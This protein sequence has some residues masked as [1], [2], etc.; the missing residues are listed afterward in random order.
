MLLTWN[1]TKQ[2]NIAQN[3]VHIKFHETVLHQYHL[4]KFWFVLLQ[5]ESNMQDRMSRTIREQY[6]Y[7]IQ[8]NEDNLRLTEAWDKAQSSV[9]ILEDEISISLFLSSKFLLSI[10]AVI[11]LHGSF[12]WLL[13][14][15]IF[16]LTESLK[17]DFYGV[18]KMCIGSDKKVLHGYIYGI[19]LRYLRCGLFLKLPRRDSF[20]EK[21]Q[22]IFINVERNNI[23]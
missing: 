15:D 19:I 11:Y 23:L 1:L 17:L 13:L 22:P 6:G 20:N 2:W 21:L 12:V 10:S 14:T 4:L 18:W 9:S 7:D 16:D 5:I 3:F 8:Y